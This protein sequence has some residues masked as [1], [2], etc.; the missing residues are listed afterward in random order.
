MC[1]D[2]YPFHKHLQKEY[3]G[4]KIWVCVRFTWTACIGFNILFAF[5]SF[6]PTQKVNSSLMLENCSGFTF[7]LN[8]FGHIVILERLISINGELQRPLA[9]SAFLLFN[10]HSKRN[11]LQEAI[12]DSSDA[13]YSHYR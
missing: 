13:T 7:T 8:L 10:L 4:R 1:F 9:Y 6:S 3:K 12:K 5:F 2:V 11:V